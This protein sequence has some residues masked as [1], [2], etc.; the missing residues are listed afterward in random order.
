MKKQL[1]I[2]SGALLT[3]SA[4]AQSTVTFENFILPSDTF[5]D[6]ASKALDTTWVGFDTLGVVFSNAYDTSFGGFWSEGFAISTKRD[7]TTAGYTNLYS[8]ITA[9]GYNSP[10]YVMGQANAVIKTNS[11]PIRP[12]AVRVTNSTYATFSMRNGDMFA[13]KFGG[14]TGNDSDWFLIT[15]SGYK[16]GSRSGD[17]VTFYLADYRFA[18]STKDYIVNTWQ[19]INLTALQTVDSI[20]ITLTSSDTGL[21]GMNTPAFYAL[22]D[23]SFDK[24]SSQS[25]HENTL[26]KYAYRIYPNP[27]ESQIEVVGTPTIDDMAVYNA[28]GARMH[29]VVIHANTVDISELPAGLYYLQL[30]R[31]IQSLKFI[32]R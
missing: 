28:A 24:N 25:V 20:V 12:L 22:D 16:N 18:D 30:N 19:N 14:V 17:S 3:L 27:A 31:G 9:S 6:G 2:L 15:F 7:S 4:G 23:F 5:N 21:F 10:T 11:N 26:D 32:K 8:A 29:E 1:L 13:K